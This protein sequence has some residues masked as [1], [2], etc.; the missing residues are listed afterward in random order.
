M[1]TNE[2]KCNDLNVTAG[3]CKTMLK[4]TEFAKEIGTP[5]ILH[6]FITGGFTPNTTLERYCRDNRLLLHIH[7]A[8]YVV[9]DR[10]KNHGIHFR[11]LAKCYVYLIMITFT[12][13]PLLTN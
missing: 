7:R 8:M 6:D 13:E 10:Q 4:R 2:V 1:K 5:I 9:I 11:V 3:T 12:L